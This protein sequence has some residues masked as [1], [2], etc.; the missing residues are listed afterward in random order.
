MAEKSSKNDSN[1]RPKGERG[2]IVKMRINAE[3]LERGEEP[4]VVV[5]TTI[6]MW[7]HVDSRLVHEEF[8]HIIRRELAVSRLWFPLR[9]RPDET[10]E[11]GGQLSGNW[12]GKT[13]L[14][15]VLHIRKDRR[16]G[17]LLLTENLLP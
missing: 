16:I 17:S 2:T 6:E 8:G 11:P 12:Q 5:A 3:P 1:D 7:R 10:G 4:R 13:A 9:E 14:F 15:N